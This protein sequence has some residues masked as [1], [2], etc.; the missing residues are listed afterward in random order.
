MDLFEEQ[1]KR[2]PERVAVSGSCESLTYLELDRRAE[3]V[4]QELRSRGIGPESIVAV[5]MERSASLIV[6]MLGV[7]KAGG[8][9][10]PV[11]PQL[12]R[13]RKAYMVQD[14]GT[15]LVLTG[16]KAGEG[17]E[18]G[19]EELD[20]EQ[21]LETKACEE[22]RKAAEQVQLSEQRLGKITSE[23]TVWEKAKHQTWRM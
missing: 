9:Y 17:R 19:V 2:V 18:L 23:G 4:A 10:L 16:S 14:S 8:A 6:A 13:E 12:P 21:L 3:E 15:K 11:D 20:V 22:A 1:V 7:L 5:M